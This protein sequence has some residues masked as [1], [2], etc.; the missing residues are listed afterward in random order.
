MSSF[1]KGGEEKPD[2]EPNRKERQKT[3]QTHLRVM[4]PTTKR[5]C[6]FTS[7]PRTNAIGFCAVS[8]NELRE[9]SL[10]GELKELHVGITYVTKTHPSSDTSKQS[11]T[12][13]F[14]KVLNTTLPH[15]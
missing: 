8:R 14:N 1:I 5:P 4:K 6:S 10:W 13:W 11:K 7:V 2:M 15:V 9:A 12:K 3:I